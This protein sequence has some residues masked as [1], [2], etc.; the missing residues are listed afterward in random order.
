VLFGYGKNKVRLFAP[1]KDNSSKEGR[2]IFVSDGWGNEKNA[3]DSKCAS[4][5]VLFILFYD[6]C[7]FICCFLC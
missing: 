5:K 7:V 2:V 1:D 4:V 3:Q 6:F